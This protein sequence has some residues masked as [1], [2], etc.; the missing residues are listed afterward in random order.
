MSYSEEAKNYANSILEHRRELN[1]QLTLL[2]KEEISVKCNA[3]TEMESYRRELNI[4]KLKASLRKENEII[5]EINKE[6]EDL[7]SEME[8]VLKKNGFTLEDLKDHYFCSICRDNGV[9]TNGRDCSCKVKL[10][11]EYELKKIQARSPLSLSSFDTFDLSYYSKEKMN[12]YSPYDIM[13][14][15][16]AVCQ[17]FCSSFPNEKDLLIMGNTGLGKTHLALSIANDILNKGHEVVYCSCSNV[18]QLIK[19][20][21]GNF[22]GSSTLDSLK[23]CDLLILDDL[24]SEYINSYYNS[25]IYDILNSR[26]SE[27]KKTVITT[28][29]NDYNQIKSRYGDKIASRLIGC[30]NILPCIGEDIRLSHILR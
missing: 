23:R 2:K 30:F 4:R 27:K 12:G 6:L 19:E 28:N 25:I 3:F 10:M 16:L 29:L 7:S 26:I 9:L 20:E 21:R 22:S 1:V 13:K 14:G 8:S 5:N 18:F 24:G 15:H 17:K 11:K